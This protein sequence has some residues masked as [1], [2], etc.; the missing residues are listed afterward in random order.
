MLFINHLHK[1][2]HK[3]FTAVKDYDTVLIYDQTACILLLGDSLFK[4]R[5]W[6]I[7]SADIAW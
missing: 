6:L 7:K 4:L 3:R 2:I 1:N 5:F